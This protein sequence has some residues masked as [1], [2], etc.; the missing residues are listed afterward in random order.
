M[1]VVKEDADGQVVMKTDETPFDIPVFTVSEEEFARRKESLVR[2]FDLGGGRLARFEIYQT[3]ENLYLFEDVHHMLCDGSSFAVLANAEQGES[4]CHRFCRCAQYEDRRT[5]LLQRRPHLA[6][7]V[8]GGS[9]I[10]GS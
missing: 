5:L 3:P 4:V 1:A 9:G 8:E 10:P 6:G 2:P 7:A